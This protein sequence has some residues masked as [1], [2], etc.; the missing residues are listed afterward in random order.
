M[1]D[2]VVVQ[3]FDTSEATDSAVVV[4]AGIVLVHLESA[5]LGRGELGLAE[6]E[7]DGGHGSR[8]A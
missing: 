2:A 4:S 8:V 5:A 7:E 3:G 1:D 6:G